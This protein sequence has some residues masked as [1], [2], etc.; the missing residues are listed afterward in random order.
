VPAG[1]SSIARSCRIGAR[2]TRRDLAATAVPF[3]RS[4]DGHLAHHSLHA[5]T[6]RL[7]RKGGITLSDG[8]AWG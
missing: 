2:L 1:P 6:L 4:I 8:E 5:L 7:R 3:A